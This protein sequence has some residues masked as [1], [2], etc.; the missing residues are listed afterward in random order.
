M[1]PRV[2]WKA[3][4][5]EVEL[6]SVREVH[7]LVGL[8]TCEGCDIVQA[9]HAPEAG[10]AQG[11][12][13]WRSHQAPGWTSGRAGRGTGGRSRKTGEEETL[14][15]Q[16]TPKRTSNPSFANLRTPKSCLMRMR[17]EHLG[18]KATAYT[19]PWHLSQMATGFVVCACVF[20]CLFVCVFV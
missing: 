14:K 4:G 15:E 5:R 20:V 17:C 13:P 8:I 10:V 19:R 9:D 7:L 12:L 16:K 2:F 3:G 18:V 11:D 1:S 6:F